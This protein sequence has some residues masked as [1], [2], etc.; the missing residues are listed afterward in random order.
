[1]KKTIKSYQLLLILSIGAISAC[2]G[3]SS[4]SDS[5]TKKDPITTYSTGIFLANVVSNIGYRSETRSGLTNSNGEFEYEDGENITFFIGDLEFP[6]VPAASI[7]TPL[8]L[9]NTTEITD[10]TVVN[11]SRLIQSLDQDGM[12]EN[13]IQIPTQASSAATSIDFTQNVTDFANDDAV[14][15][16]VANA[17]STNTALISETD[18]IAHLSDTLSQTII[19][20]VAF[21]TSQLIGQSVYR[22]YFSDEDCTRS[23]E[24]ATSEVCTPI[25]DTNIFEFRSN[26]NFD[27]YNPNQRDEAFAS[28]SYTISENAQRIEIQGTL[29]ADDTVIDAYIITPS[30]QSN[31]NYYSVCFVNSDTEESDILRCNSNEYGDGDYFFFDIDDVDNFIEANGRSEG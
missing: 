12:P 13:G 14:I 3:G 19:S 26:G 23:E 15:N 4:N 16:L 24:D 7:I 8:T 25:Y 11:I 20:S 31:D 5:Q 18:A 29:L 9:A 28:G 2:G 17:G 21:D 10:P 22:I 27:V 1:M 30:Y 6:T